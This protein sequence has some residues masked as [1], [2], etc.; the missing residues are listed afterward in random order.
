ML[1]SGSDS[2]GFPVQELVEYLDLCATVFQKVA[3]SFDVWASEVHV[4]K[5]K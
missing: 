5:R 1:R 4:L 3:L 2:N